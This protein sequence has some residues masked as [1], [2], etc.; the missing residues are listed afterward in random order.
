VATCEDRSVGV[1]LKQ[2]V[3]GVTTRTFMTEFIDERSNPEPPPRVVRKP[4]ARG[5]ELRELFGLC[6]AGCFSGGGQHPEPR[7]YG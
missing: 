3:S 2:P 7:V 1:E 6:V 4:A 5:E